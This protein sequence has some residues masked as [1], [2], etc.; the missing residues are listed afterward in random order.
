MVLT[1]QFATVLLKFEMV[2]VHWEVPLAFIEVL[3]QTTEVAGTAAVV[4]LEP[5]EFKSN[6]TG[7]SANIRRTFC[8]PGLR[9]QT[10]PLG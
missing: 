8:N 6:N 9:A 7:R 3:A 10:R 1:C 5:Q 4:V 2:A